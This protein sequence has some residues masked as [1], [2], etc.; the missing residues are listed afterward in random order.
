MTNLL[1]ESLNQTAVWTTITWRILNAF[2]TVIKV[3]MVSK[4]EAR[5]TKG[6]KVIICL[7]ALKNKVYSPE[8]GLNVVSTLENMGPTPDKAEYWQ[9][10]YTMQLS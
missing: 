10:R 8:N 4:G 1:K 5:S 9:K 7:I 2:H 6:I 3:M